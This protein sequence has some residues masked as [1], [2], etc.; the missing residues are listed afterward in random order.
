[1]VQQTV[2]RKREPDE[3]IPGVSVAHKVPAKEQS[4]GKLAVIGQEAQREKQD[5][6]PDA[7]RAKAVGEEIKDQVKDRPE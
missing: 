2:D 5:G 4:L 3:D 1:M 7:V 6:K